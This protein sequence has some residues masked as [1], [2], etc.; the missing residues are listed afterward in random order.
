MIIPKSLRTVVPLSVLLVFLSCFPVYAQKTPSPRPEYMNALWIAKSDGI[1]KVATTD[2]TVLLEIVEARNVRA[3]AVDEQRGLLWAYGRGILRAYGFNGE[4]LLSVFIPSTGDEEGEEEDKNTNGKNKGKG[5]GKSE[6]GDQDNE[7]GEE[8]NAHHLALSVNPN[9]GTVWLAIGKSLYHFDAQGRWLTTLTLPEKVRALALDKASWRLWVATKQGIHAYDDAGAVVKALD[10]GAHPDVLALAIDAGSGALWVALKDALRRYDAGGALLLEVPIDRPRQIVG[11]GRGGVWVVTHKKLIRMDSDGRMRLETEP[12]EGHGKLIALVADPADLSVWV[13]N[14]KALAHIH[15]DGQPLHEMEFRSPIRAL[16][17][18]ADT[19]PPAIALTAPP[20]GALLN[21][22]RPPIEVEYGDI[23]SGMDPESLLLWANDM[24]LAATCTHSEA[25]A[26]CMPTGALPEGEI[27]LAATIR[28][29]ASNSA[30]PAEVRFTIDTIPPIITLTVPIDGTLTRE[31]LQLFVGHLSE[32]ATLTLNGE[33]IPLGPNHEFSHGPLPLQE[34]PNPF[35]LVATDSADNRSHL[36]VRVTLDTVPPAAIEGKQLQIG[37]VTRGQVAISGGAGSVEAGARVMISN[38]RTGEQVTVNTQ[39]DGSFAAT[40]SAQSGDELSIVLTDGAGN[41]S[42]PTPMKVG[43]GLPPDP[44][45]VAPPVDH[46]VATSLST[47]TAFLYTGPNPIQTGVAPGTI[48]PRRA[49]VLRGR[50]FT[51]EGLPLSEVTLTVLDHPEFGQTLSRA[52]GMFDLAV[53]GG[54]RL[55]VYYTKEGY[56]PVQRHLQVPWQDY[57]WLPEV[58][59]IPWDP[60]VTPIDLTESGDFQVAQGSPVTDDDGT[61]AATLLFPPGTQATLMLPDGTSRPLNTLHVRATEYTVGQS[62]PQAMP[63]GLPPNSGYTYAV[64]FSADEAL[65]AGATEVRFTPPLISYVENFLN[66]PVGGIVPVGYYDRTQRCCWIPS[67]NGRVIRVLSTNH[68]LAELD[69]NVDGMA[70]D[71]A[72]LAALGI[73]EAERQRLAT[74][75]PPGQSLWRVIIAHFTPWDYN[76]PYGSPD[77]AKAPGQG[78]PSGDDPLEDSC[79]MSGSIIECQNQALGEAANLAGTPFGL[80]YRSDRVP[81]RK[82]AYT[83]EIPLS[84][85][86]LPASLKR[87]ELEISVVGRRFTQ[88]FPPAPDQKYTFTWDGQDAYGRVLQGAQPVTI[89]IGYIYDAV[90]QQP[91][92]FARSFAA[93]SG[94]PITGSRAR[95]EITLWQEWQS[96]IGSWNGQGQ[97][98]GGWS[99]SVHHAY[100][101]MARVFSLGD[102]GRRSAEALGQVI[103][104]VAGNGIQ[105]FDGDDGPATMAKLWLPYGVAVGPEGSFYIADTINNRIRRVDPRGII[106]TVAGNGEWGYGGDGGPATLAKL[107]SPYGVTVGPDGSLY[108]ADTGNSRVR[109]V[110]PEGIITTV[111]GNGERGYSGDGGPATLAK[112]RSVYG[113]AVGPDCSLYLADYADNRI[114][115]VSPEGIITTVVGNGTPGYSGD[116]GPAAAA[117]L[118]SPYGVAVGADGSLYIADFGNSRIRR[119]GPEGIITTVVG[120]GE[121]EYSGDGGPATQAQLYWPRAV[122][123]GPDGSLYIADTDN[124]RIRRVDPG[125]IITTVAGNGKPGYSGDGGLAVAAELYDPRAVAVGADGSLYIPDPGY[126]RIRRVAPSL[127]GLSA[128]ELLIPAEDGSELYVFDGEG[129]HLRTLNALT[130][131]VRYRFSYDSAGLLAAVTDGDGNVTTIERDADGNPT[132]IVAPFGQ[133]TTLSLDANGH[134]ASITNPAGEATRFSYTDDGL[135]LTLTDPKDNVHRFTYDALGRL[136]RDEDPAGGF[137][138]LTRSESDTGYTVAVTTA[139]NRVHTY[140][141]EKLSTGSTHRVN[142]DP[143]GARTEVILGPDGSRTI[144]L[145]DGTTTTL[146]QGPDPRWGMQAFFPS[147][148][149]LTTPGGLAASGSTS[150]SVTLSD[151]GDPFSLL[152]LTDT[153]R[154]NGRTY[155]NTYDATTGKMT[156]NTPSGRT[157]TMALGMLGQLIQSEVPGIAPMQYFYNDKGRITSLVQGERTYVMT[158][159][160]QGNLAD[161][162]DP[163]SRKVKFE[164]DAA[165]RITKWILADGREILYSYDANGNVRSITPPGRPEHSFD[166]T[167]VDLEQVHFPPQPQPSTPDPRTIFTY[168]LDK[169]LTRITR[170]DGTAID[171]G[172]DN[173]GRLTTITQ[174]WGQTSLFYD[175]ATGSLKTIMAPDGGTITYGYDGPLLLSTTWAGAVAGAVNQTYDN[176]WRT[177]ST[178]VNGSNTINLGYDQDGLLLQAG[179]L[180]LN[181]DPQNGLLLGSTLDSITDTLSYNAFGEPMSYGATSSGNPLFDVQYTRDSLGRITHKTELVGGATHHYTYTYDL[182]GRLTEVRKDGLLVAQYEYDLNGNR[183]KKITSEGTITGTYDAQDRLLTYGNATYTYTANGELLTKTIPGQTTEYLYDTLGNLVAVTLPDGTQIEYILDGRNRRIGKKVNG[184]LVQSF[185]YANQLNPV[186]ELDGSNILVSRFVYAGKT[187]V[188][189]YMIRDNVTYRIIT[190]HLGSPRLVIDV[191]TGQIV[192]R[193]DYDEFGHITRDTNPGF[194]PFGFAGGMYDEHTKLVRFGARDYDPEMGRWTAKDPI[195]F[196]GG[197]TNLYGYVLNDPINRIDPWGLGGGKDPACTEEKQVFFNWVHKAIEQMAD[198]LNVPENFLLILAAK[199]GGWTQKNH[200][201]NMPLN[202]P[203]GVNRINEKGQAAGN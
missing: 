96:S 21:T 156:F 184:I 150:R 117:K 47:A 191:A 146:A 157:T 178:S 48:E 80:H 193:I 87:I 144:T 90:Y 62:G 92:Q 86:S 119:V 97:G 115:R 14:Q 64:E 35:D 60:Q 151:P 101:P 154:I 83:L 26:T 37:D 155:T 32:A 36:R 124:S 122:A 81:G 71:A 78:A 141:V 127:P 198:N 181:R 103:T 140:L 142:T 56:L 107:K 59:M 84:R 41:A 19:I 8:G 171:F 167:Q 111:A 120:N 173:A 25:G 187:N 132:A 34:G 145:P 70:D 106:T 186:A 202:N 4:P 43:S 129:R 12:L 175:P 185:L 42:P 195:D 54:G 112:L 104:T 161:I 45:T 123:V 139:L 199:E 23:G 164:Y 22:N 113:V 125:G 168:N 79:E 152:E 20:D 72:T 126:T 10:L 52:D 153:L 108:I 94:V 75:Y 131:A 159:D 170:P 121:P 134:L 1:L 166:Y 40:I 197:N 44:A 27:L 149:S 18:Y 91:A 148:F 46:T 98:L 68:G 179:A 61:R 65:A 200:Y 160:P 109:R 50:V 39:A 143:S 182:A 137:K 163:L 69:T 17:L 63:A 7:D 88:S 116:G 135:L 29:Y 194:Q 9:S 189:D 138:A 51:R 74:L 196:D 174:P 3:L 31:A 30:E 13:A 2:A 55:T 28:D 6:G 190:D 24:E 89:R 183:L 100:H 93:F 128:D 57:A 11:E 162:A 176:N 136:T 77:D 114:R 67:D 102:G 133:R 82:A 85:A 95:Q 158:Y 203:F 53:N 147:S 73:T 66:F 105:G 172:R 165:G 76:W 180:S 16:A 201:H 99:L 33:A 169:Q 130:G 5:E 38:L 58:V 15:S 49:A 118:E 192:Q 188:P 177:T 110:D